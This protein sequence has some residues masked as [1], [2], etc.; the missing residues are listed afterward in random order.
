MTSRDF[1]YWLQSAFELADIKQFSEK[2]TEMI[3]RHLH[4]VFAHEIDPSFGGPTAQAILDALHEPPK[5]QTQSQ[6]FHPHPNPL[7]KC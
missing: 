1:C 6:P 5:P 4:M 7:I 3:R 2:Q